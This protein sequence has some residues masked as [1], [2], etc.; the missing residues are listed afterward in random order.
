M[1]LRESDDVPQCSSV[2]MCTVCRRQLRNPHL[3]PCLHAFCLA[4]L[5]DECS[6]RSRDKYFCPVCVDSSP[7]ESSDN[8]SIGGKK[9]VS[10]RPW[11]SF[12]KI[13]ENEAAHDALQRRLAELPGEG[14]DNDF[15]GD[16]NSG[17]DDEEE[18]PKTESGSSLRQSC[19]QLAPP[20][21]FPCSNHSEKLTDQFCTKCDQIACPKC[22]TSF[23]RRCSQGS[24]QNIKEVVESRRRGF[25]SLHNAI[26]SSLTLC[27][28]A[29]A[30]QTARAEMVEQAR[31]RLLL[32]IRAT[33][34]EMVSAMLAKEKTLVEEVNRLMNEAKE[35]AEQ[36]AGTAA[37]LTVSLARQLDVMNFS[38]GAGAE[39]ELLPY[40]LGLESHARAD[41]KLAM[42]R[43]QEAS[44]AEVVFHRDDVLEKALTE[45]PLG[46]LKIEEEE[47]SELQ[48]RVV[49]GKADGG[50][51]RLGLILTLVTSF[52]GGA[53]DDISEPLLTDLVLLANGDVILTD[54]DNH[55][56]K[57]FNRS[58]KLLTRVMLDASPS[59]IAVV[60]HGRAVVSTTGRREL[61]FLSLQGTV[62]ILSSVRVKKL[63]T[64]LTSL[65][66]GVLAAGTN[67]GDCLDLITEEGRYIKTIF[68]CK[69]ERAGISRPFYITP[70]HH[71]HQQN[72]PHH[73]Q[74][75]LQT[76]TEVNGAEN[77]RNLAAT[78]IESL[79][80]S[81]DNKNKVARKQSPNNLNSSIY[82]TGLTTS[83]NGNNHRKASVAGK[84]KAGV[85]SSNKNIATSSPSAASSNNDI[86][87]NGHSSVSKP[88]VTIDPTSSSSTSASSTS[89]MNNMNSGP[90]SI[91]SIPSYPSS[92]VGYST[93]DLW[94]TDS[95]K[96]II[97][98]LR[99]TD[100]KTTFTL[101]S[102]SDLQL[103]LECPL[104][105][106]VHPSGLTLLVDRDTDSVLLLDEGS[107]YIRPVLTAADGVSRPCAIYAGHRGHV[108][109]SQVDGMV[110]IYSSALQYF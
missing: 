92:S 38:L 25:D 110:K 40:L 11:H 22:I 64:F 7:D 8:K 90:S 57:K 35:D 65:G 82:N 49:D 6:Q 5:Q 15:H 108:A 86:I 88:S 81:S 53:R 44:H 24:I 43:L 79:H 23:H 78:S 75:C 18:D 61:Y 89:D 102:R 85:N 17:S 98:R 26:A 12:D 2:L 14:G 42:G 28:D 68:S 73:D 13:L 101:K 76:E 50:S 84:S 30:T 55:C 46:F 77:H 52:H 80:G 94:I 36:K 104:G 56:V 20:A 63:Y 27:E 41:A 72:P 48:K 66:G 97:Y 74:G 1:S 39:G 33:R 100:G 19:Q 87:N 29:Q 16:D 58:G 32:A 4:C 54:R 83:S 70:V 47:T 51:R 93:D 96:K 95:A 59:R 9:S 3:L 62:R 31:A 10:S 107:N 45:S 71:E 99:Q 37:K 109:L 34:E 103:T 60:S 106:T 69:P 91:S 21:I 105:V 67:Y